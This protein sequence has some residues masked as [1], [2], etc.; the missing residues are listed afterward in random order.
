MTSEREEKE[1]PT[2]A[3]EPADLSRVLKSIRGD[4]T[5]LG[6]LIDNF[7]ADCPT[8]RL[9]LQHGAAAGNA[10]EVDREAH[11][12]RGTLL[13]FGAEPA[14]KLALELEVLARS[15]RLQGVEEILR[16]LDAELDQLAAFLA[17]R[18]VASP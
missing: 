14:A 16:R 2:A 12:L 1:R 5:L 8:R 6:R 9:A 13:L 7:L 3:S 15:G 11:G 18:Q 4:E 17:R 10:E